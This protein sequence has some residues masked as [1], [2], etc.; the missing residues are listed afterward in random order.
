MIETYSLSQRRKKN[1]NSGPL[2]LPPSMET[3]NIQ[4]SIWYENNLFFFTENL[5][6]SSAAVTKN[7]TLKAHVSHCLLYKNCLT[8]TPHT[9]TSQ[10]PCDRG[11][12]SKEILT[13]WIADKQLLSIYTWEPEVIPWGIFES[14]S[15]YLYHLYLNVFMI[16]YFV[17]YHFRN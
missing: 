15:C 6:W 13:A 11:T 5:I 10:F 14:I 8:D 12:K 9:P 1:R 17:W 7:H 3:W 4:S 16:Q 2:L